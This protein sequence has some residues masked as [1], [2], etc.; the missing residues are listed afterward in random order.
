MYSVNTWSYMHGHIQRIYMVLTSP[1]H[2]LRV[3]SCVRRYQGHSLVA[4]TPQSQ[5]SS[6]KRHVLGGTK[7]TK[8]VACTP[9]V[10]VDQSASS[11]KSHVLGGTKGTKL[12]T[13][14]PQVQVTSCF[15]SYQGH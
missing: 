9:Q 6:R 11:R 4:C 10:Q 8:L 2:E 15:T 1:R 13:C 5:A 7:N 12:I 3:K 14:T